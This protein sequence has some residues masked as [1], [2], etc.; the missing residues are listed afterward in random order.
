MIAWWHRRTLAHRQLMSAASTLVEAAF[1]WRD[2]GSPGLARDFLSRAVDR[3][4]V[5]GCPEAEW[6]PVVRRALP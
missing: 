4:V 5:C 1:H 3:V 6:P 2:R